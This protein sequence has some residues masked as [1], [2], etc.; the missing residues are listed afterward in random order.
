M[1][2]QIYYKVVNRTD[3]KSAIVDR[4]NPHCIQYLV[5]EWACPK[6]PQA[7]LFVFETLE[8]A[9]N[10]AACEKTYA[11]YTC[12]IIRCTVSEPKYILNVFQI[13][14]RIDTYWS[15]IRLQND[16]W[17]NRPIIPGTVFADAVKLLEM[18]A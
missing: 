7:P 2:D 5:N 16:V 6:N 15:I 9:L 4:E 8:H 14:D 1:E 3:L 11:I 12:H 13:E 10:F 18:V 17:S